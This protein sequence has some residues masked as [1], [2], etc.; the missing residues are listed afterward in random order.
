[1]SHTEQSNN[2]ESS[3][4]PLVA[5]GFLTLMAVAFLD[6]VRG[7][8]L[9]VLCR[10]LDIPYQDAGIFL[11]VG[12]IAAVASVLLMGRLLNRYNEK[13]VLIGA[14][15]FSAIPGFLAPWIK[16]FWGLI[17]L[18]IFIGASVSII[19]SLSNILTLQGASERN[20][21]R[22][23]SAQQ[24]MYGLGSFLAPLSFSIAM[25]WQ[26][27][28]WSVLVLATGIFL[29]YSL[30]FLRIIDAKRLRQQSQNLAS[31]TFRF[32]HTH[33]AQKIAV[34]TFGT[35]VG[36]EVLG[37]MWMASLMVDHL[38]MSDTEA[39]SIVGYFFL[40]VA[41]SRLL[42][43]LLVRPQWERLVICAALL[44]GI[45]GLLLG[46]QGVLFGF[47]IAACVGP[48]FPLFMAEVS[49]QFPTV[50]RQIAIWIFVSIQSSL[51]LVHLSTGKLSDWLG[52]DQAFLLAPLLLAFTLVLYLSFDRLCRKSTTERTK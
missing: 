3:N 5:A 4:I 38:Q 12:N 20:R 50:W 47:V 27:S 35:Y 39:A 1:M 37:S 6:N 33:L 7:P 13:Y 14:C 51:G 40:G 36:G 32:R 34:L 41:G 48:F 19:G 45:L 26:L 21:G 42:S 8:L 25:N 29:L 18:G 11:T 10:E 28:W 31:R 46:Q 15:L 44:A 52:I 22:I 16:G 2:S 17:L 24:V 43:F 30:V 49:R 23:L 9:P